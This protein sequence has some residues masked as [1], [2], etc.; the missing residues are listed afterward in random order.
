ME[1]V[2]ALIDLRI[3]FRITLS[4]FTYEPMLKNP[5]CLFQSRNEDIQPFS[6]SAKLSECEQTPM[7]A[8]TTLNLTRIN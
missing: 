5:E 4:I 7:K 2:V 1:S 8:L 6:L 3:T